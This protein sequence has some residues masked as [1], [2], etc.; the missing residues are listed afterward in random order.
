MGMYRGDEACAI[1]QHTILLCRGAGG[2]GGGNENII[3]GVHKYFA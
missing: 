1:E 3:A 2:I